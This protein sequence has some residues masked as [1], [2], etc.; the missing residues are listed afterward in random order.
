MATDPDMHTLFTREAAE[1]LTSTVVT[2]VALEARRDVFAAMLFAYALRLPAATTDLLSI[3]WIDRLDLT[4]KLLKGGMLPPEVR[5]SGPEP[6][7]DTWLVKNIEHLRESHPLFAE[8]AD[9]NDERL[10][11]EAHLPVVH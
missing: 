9:L 3:A 1:D 4:E 5:L 11:I 10:L 6:L 2:E 7:A 8:W